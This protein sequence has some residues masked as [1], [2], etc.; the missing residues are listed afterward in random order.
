[1][2]SIVVPYL[3]AISDR[4]SPALTV[5]VTVDGVEV[6]VAVTGAVGKGVKVGCGVLVG[7][8]VETL[9]DGKRQGIAKL[10]EGIRQGVAG[11]MYTLKRTITT[12]KVT[13]TMGRMMDTDGIRRAL[14]G[15]PHI[16]QVLAL[17]ATAIPHFG[18]LLTFLLVLKSRPPMPPLLV[19]QIPATPKSRP[20]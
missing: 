9:I 3:A 17:E 16:K 10:T 4:L 14:R 1:M 11:R 12:A 13:T 20:S 15:A 18:H 6:G 2:A 5:W 19:N 7:A 8:T